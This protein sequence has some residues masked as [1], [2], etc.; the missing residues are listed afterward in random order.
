MILGE[1]GSIR[2]DENFLMVAH[3][4]STAH[5]YANRIGQ[6]EIS[7]SG[8]AG[9]FVGFP[10]KAMDQVTVSGLVCSDGQYKM[11]I[12]QGTA[13]EVSHDEWIEGGSKMIGKLR[14]GMKPSEF[15]DCMMR[16]G[17]D[18]HLIIKEG[19]HTLELA[20]ICDYLGIE[21]VVI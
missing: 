17:L 9:C 1:T 18:H 7:P 21:K 15:V 14:F 19:D 4:G 8:D 13:L 6:V 3:E 20:M 16:A 11:L 5:S 2:D 10:V 12:A